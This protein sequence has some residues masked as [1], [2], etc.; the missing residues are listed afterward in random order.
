ME[1]NYLNPL[2]AESNNSYE[3]VMA[4]KELKEKGYK[5]IQANHDKH[6]LGNLMFDIVSMS[7]HGYTYK[8]IVAE[9]LHY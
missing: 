9:L 6:K 7:K 4:L 1:N 8:E 3:L 5:Y 2:I